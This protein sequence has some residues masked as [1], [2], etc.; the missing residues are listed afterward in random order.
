MP[1]YKSTTTIEDWARSEK[2]HDSFL[3]SKDYILDAVANHSASLGLPDVAV[4]ESQGKFLNLLARSIG[5]KRILEIG[6][7]AGF[8]AIQFA[9]AV[10][11]DGNVTTLE[12]DPLHAKV[13]SENFERAGVAKKITLLV[14][15]AADSLVALDPEKLFDLVFID[16]DKL[17]NVIYYTEAKRLLRSGGI[18]IVDNAVYDGKVADLEFNDDWALGVRELLAV[19]KDDK[20]VEAVTIPTVGARGFDGFIYAIRK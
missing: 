10:P 14:G 7:L 17:S 9:R 16:A 8:S 20:E 15:R 12:L 1:F 4:S 11:D 3:L 6:T 2:F 18:I 13:A 5:A 19:M